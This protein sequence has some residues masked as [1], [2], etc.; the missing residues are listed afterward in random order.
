MNTSVLDAIKEG[1]WDF[2]PEMV[3]DTQYAPTQAIPGSVQKVMVLAERLERGL[4][5]WHPADRIHHADPALLALAD[6]G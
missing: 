1:V 3:E 6:I 2:E 5:L 4:P